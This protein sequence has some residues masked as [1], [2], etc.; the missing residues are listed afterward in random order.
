MIDILPSSLSKVDYTKSVSFL[1]SELACSL[2][3]EIRICLQSDHSR[4]YHLGR[5]SREELRCRHLAE[6]SPCT[7]HFSW[8]QFEGP[9]LSFSFY[10][11]NSLTPR[12]SRTS[13]KSPHP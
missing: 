13:S 2:A 12:P 9:G 6:E 1:Q 11:I 8:E 4:K 10:R 5:S 7:L 3:D